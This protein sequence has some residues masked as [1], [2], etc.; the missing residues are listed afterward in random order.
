VIV[1]D[2]LS[3]VE[4]SEHPFSEGFFD[5]FEVDLREPGEHAA[6]PVSVSEE[7]VK[8]WSTGG[9]AVCL[10]VFRN[11]APYYFGGKAAL[12][13]ASSSTPLN[14]VF[15]ASSAFFV[16]PGWQLGCIGHPGAGV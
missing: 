6:L 16:A 9:W 13:R 2:K 4:L 12:F 15:I 7:S 5:W 11:R 1:R 8:V 3:F 10:T 14:L